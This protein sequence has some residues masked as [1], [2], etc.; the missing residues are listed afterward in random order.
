[1]AKI[2]ETIYDWRFWIL[3]GFIVIG[4]GTAVYLYWESISSCW[5]RVDDDSPTEPFVPLAYEGEIHG[6]SRFSGELPSPDSSHSSG[7]SF[8]KFF[9]TPIL[10][11]INNFRNKVKG[12][13]LNKII[14]TT[15]QTSEAR[16]IPR[17]IYQVEG[18]DMYNGLPLPRVEFL[19]N[20][21]EYYFNKDTHGFIS[22]VNNKF[23]SSENIISI[24]PF[25]GRAISCM[26]AS[27]NERVALINKA[28][29]SAFCEAPGNSFARNP[30]F[31]GVELNIGQPSLSS[32]SA[33]YSSTLPTM[34][35]QSDLED[36]DLTPKARPMELDMENPFD[37]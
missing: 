24:N 25:S 34:S 4:I 20:G 35:N 6:P 8:N 36:I 26:P 5:K 23:G 22:V 3:G 14:K 13:F 37:S 10:D 27:I 11:K 12:Y 1:L 32:T 29:D 18:R 16:D 2:R 33:A 15:N 31:E 28:R 9:K 17:G 30:I 21:T 19:D 7:N